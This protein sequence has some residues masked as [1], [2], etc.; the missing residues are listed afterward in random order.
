MHNKVKISI[1]K[2]TNYSWRD[3]EHLGWEGIEVYIMSHRE[4]GHFAGPLNLLP[5][6]LETDAM[7][8]NWFQI[9]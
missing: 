8:L 5:I 3:N 2:E 6:A 9:I 4:K 7:Q 1:F